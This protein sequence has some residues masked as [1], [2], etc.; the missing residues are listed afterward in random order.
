M[1]DLELQNKALN[2]KIRRLNYQLHI[3]RGVDESLL[4]QNAK[5]VQDLKQATRKNLRELANE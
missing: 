3:L 2:N 4:Q 1:S 5:L